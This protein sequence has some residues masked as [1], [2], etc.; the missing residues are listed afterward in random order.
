MIELPEAARIARQITRT[1]KGRRIVQ[2]I[3]GNTPH[4]WAFYSRPTEEYAR[5]MT[6]KRIGDSRAVGSLIVTDIRPG[7]ALVLG[8]GGERIIHHKSAAT[9]PAK[10]QL[11]L[12][13]DNSTYLTVNVQGWGSVQL[14]DPEELARHTCVAG[15]GF[16][17]TDRAF[18]LAYLGKLIDAIAA[19]D[20]RSVKFFLISKPGVLGVGNGYL[21]D[22]CFRARIHPLTRIV[23]LSG[24]Q[25]KV[26]YKSIVS[27][28]RQ[29]MKQNGRDDEVDLFGKPG[30]Y[31]RILSSRA[32]G[33]PCPVCQEKI[34]RESFL[35]GAIYFCPKCQPAP[36]EAPSHEDRGRTS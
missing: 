20:P 15:K 10:H 23:T 12:R 19:D 17:P 14:F 28:I 4:K 29:A 25:R 32:A 31:H 7:H 11:L 5:I 33:R 6:G 8:G 1:L 13:F 30:A 35:G 22:I 21:Q 34:V 16:M 26:L 9:L 2:V 18:T 27:T 3:R 24:E 36:P